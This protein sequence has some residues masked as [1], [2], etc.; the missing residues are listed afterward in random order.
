MVPL[1]A[2]TSACSTHTGKPCITVKKG[3]NLSHRY[4]QLHI[5]I[6][7]LPEHQLQTSDD[8]TLRRIAV[9]VDFARG[10]T[11]LCG[12]SKKIKWTS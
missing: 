3:K 5:R 2:S 6:Y 8:N 11:R 1:E 7:T 12:L 9:S 4:Y 10:A